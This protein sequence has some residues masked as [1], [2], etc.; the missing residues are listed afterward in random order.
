[1]DRAKH[2]TV[3]WGMSADQFAQEFLP[4]RFRHKH[5]ILASKQMPDAEGPEAELRERLWLLKEGGFEHQRSGWELLLSLLHAWTAASEVM[6]TGSHTKLHERVLRLHA[7]LPAP[8]KRTFEL[9]RLARRRWAQAVDQ[10]KRTEDDHGMRTFTERFQAWI[11]RTDETLVHRVLLELGKQLLAPKK[12]GNA[13]LFL[14]QVPL[15]LLSCI[16]T[17]S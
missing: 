7:Q 12:K 11:N 3:E 10:W 2:G 13:S 15:D 9:V 16:Y 1:V 6:P 4:E 14:S 8:C 17:K 5:S